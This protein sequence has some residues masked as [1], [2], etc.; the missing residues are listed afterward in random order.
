MIHNVGYAWI[1]LTI[2]TYLCSNIIVQCLI[3][4]HLQYSNMWVVS[5]IG[6]IPPLSLFLLHR[7]QLPPYAKSYF[8]TAFPMALLNMGSAVSYNSALSYARLSTVTVLTSTAS[9]F[10]LIFEFFLLHDVAVR[11]VTAAAAVLSTLGCVIVSAEVFDAA[12]DTEDAGKKTEITGIVL[13][14]VSAGIS[15][16]FSV[17][18]KKL[19]IADFTFFLPCMSAGI[20]A[21]GPIVVGVSSAGAGPSLTVVAAVLLNGSVGMA[22]NFAQMKAISILSPVVVNVALACLIPL[23]ILWDAVGRGNGVSVIFLVGAGVVVA[24]TALVALSP[25]VTPPPE[26]DSLVPDEI[27]GVSRDRLPLLNATA[28]PVV[29]K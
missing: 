7:S 26:E 5:I 12:G 8:L 29:N 14:L 22:G 13:A 2:F 25:P 3:Q 28:V 6:N 21:I 17:L 19:R 9:I 16:L 11:P 20:L 1:S 15:G 23:S 4:N 18:I 24:A 27:E 10:A